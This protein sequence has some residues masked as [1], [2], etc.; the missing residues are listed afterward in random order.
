MLFRSKAPEGKQIIQELI[1]SVGMG[2]QG[3]MTDD[4]AKML[5][6]FTVLRLSGLVGTLGENPLTKER[7]LAI[8]ARLNQVAKA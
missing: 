5:G 4:F 2:G 1:A 6:G 3:K 7:L 8:N